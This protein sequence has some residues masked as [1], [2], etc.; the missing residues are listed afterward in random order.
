MGYRLSHRI[1]DNERR[2]S[3][4]SGSV[5][6]WH[7][8]LALFGALG[9]VDDN[10]LVIGRRRFELQNPRFQKRDAFGLKHLKQAHVEHEVN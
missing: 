4:N 3:R 1:D 10:R 5:D 7:R 9:Q 2:D 8:F 6:W